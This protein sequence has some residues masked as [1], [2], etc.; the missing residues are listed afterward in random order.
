M[1]YIHSHYT[2]FRRLILRILPLFKPRL[3]Q[4]IPVCRVASLC[5]VI[6]VSMRQENKKWIVLGSNTSVTNNTSPLT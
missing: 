2:S 3:T 5:N 4:S 6:N 1:L